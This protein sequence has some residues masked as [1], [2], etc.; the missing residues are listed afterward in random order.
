[1]SDISISLEGIYNLLLNTNSHKA[2]GPDQINGRVLKETAYIISPFLKVLFQ[3]SLDSGVI[4]VDWHSANITPLFNQGNRQL[5]SNYWSISLTSI[6]SKLFEQII[7]LN[8]MK[9]VPR[10]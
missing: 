3:S 9:H 4:L 5:P 2:C 10:S 8:I 1:M 6:V 7:N